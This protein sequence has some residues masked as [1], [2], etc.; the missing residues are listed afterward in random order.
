M[1]FLKS[2]YQQIKIKAELCDLS[3]IHLAIAG[4]SI[5]FLLFSITRD[6]RVLMYSPLAKSTASLIL[7]FPLVSTGLVLL[8]IALHCLY[9]KIH[10]IRRRIEEQEYGPRK[11]IALI[12]PCIGITIFIN[13]L[14]AFFMLVDAFVAPLT[15]VPLVT[16]LCGILLVLC[17]WEVS[18]VTIRR[19]VV[20]LS[21]LLALIL[22]L[23]YIDFS[24]RKPFMRDL[25]KLRIGM[26]GAQVQAIMDRYYH[27]WYEEEGEHFFHLDPA[28][29]GGK[30]YR[31]TKEGWANAD[32][33]RVEFKEGRV[34]DVEICL[35]D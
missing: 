14:I 23:N 19:R 25:S 20:M 2:S 21:M 30:M 9:L 11:L 35:C 8:S 29:T 17:V 5:L 22:S 1:Q 32:W 12:T 7:S 31:H 15:A 34:V 28:Y 33:G 4:I 27:N 3:H 6:I 24:S 18:K 26:T 13:F 16:S 10:E